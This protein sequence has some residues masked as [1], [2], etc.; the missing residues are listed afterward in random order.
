M[1]IEGVEVTTFSGGTTRKAPRRRLRRL[2]LAAFT[3]QYTLIAIGVGLPLAA[4]LHYIVTPQIVGKF[5]A[6]ATALKR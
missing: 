2:L 1:S 3:A 5:Q 6:V 4:T